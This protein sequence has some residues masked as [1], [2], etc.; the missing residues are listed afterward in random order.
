[1]VWV[2]N[3]VCLLPSPLFSTPA[4]LASLLLALLQTFHLLLLGNKGLA[5]RVQRL[6]SIQSGRDEGRARRS[7]CL[8]GGRGHGGGEG[9]TCL[10]WEGHCRGPSWARGGD[11]DPAPLLPDAVLCISNLTRLWG[12]RR[13]KCWG[14]RR[15]RFRV[16]APGP[17]LLLRILRVTI[18]PVWLFSIPHLASRTEGPNF[19]LN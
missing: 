16:E 5:S 13:R 10:A 1:M 15:T 6:R 4:P 8:E 2:H 11:R 17:P 7:S 19:K 14:T 12:R 18:C 3:S 9:P